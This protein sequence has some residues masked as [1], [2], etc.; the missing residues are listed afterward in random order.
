[1]E[2]TLPAEVSKSERSED[3]VEPKLSELQRSTNGG[4]SIRSA[5]DLSHLQNR[6]ESASQGE[7]GIYGSFIRWCMANCEPSRIRE[8]WFRFYGPDLR[9]GHSVSNQGQSMGIASSSKNHR[10]ARLSVVAHEYTFIPANDT[11][12]GTTW[13]PR[14]AG[15]QVNTEALARWPRFP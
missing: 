12:C 6:T 1:M 10:S 4:G 8:Y 5:T 9:N 15:S 3:V 14:N 11:I 7:L 13:L 2:S